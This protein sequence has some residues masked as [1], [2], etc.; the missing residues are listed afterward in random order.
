[1]ITTLSVVFGVAPCG[2]H[3]RMTARSMVFT[4]A[5]Y[6]KTRLHEN[7]IVLM[8]YVYSVHSLMVSHVIPSSRT[9]DKNFIIKQSSL[10]GCALGLGM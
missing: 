9:D 10:F 7:N 8:L 5:N 1:M 4:A 3:D 6:Y 2:A